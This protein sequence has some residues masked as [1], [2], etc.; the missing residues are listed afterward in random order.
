M[1]PVDKVQMFI[2]HL[3]AYDHPLTMQGDGAAP[4]PLARLRPIA[5]ISSMY[6]IAGAARRAWRK[7]ERIPCS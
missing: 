2:S 7:S 1:Q 4:L 3:D 5:S 6:M